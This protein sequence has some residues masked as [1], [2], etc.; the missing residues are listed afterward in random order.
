MPSAPSSRFRSLASHLVSSILLA[1]CATGEA[2][3]SPE[4][5]LLAHYESGVSTDSGALD[6]ANLDHWWTLYDDPQLVTWIDAAFQGAFSLREAKARLVEARA[7]RSVALAQ[8]DPQGNL[9]AQGEYRRTRDLDSEQTATTKSASASLPVAWEV[10]FFGRRS[11]SAGG[12]DAD[13]AAARFQ[14]ESARAATAAEVARTLFQVRGFAAQ[15]RETRQSLRIAQELQQLVQAR[16]DRG[17]APRSEVDR[18]AVEAGQATAQAEDLQAALSASR[19]ALLVAVGRGTDALGA[20]AAIFDVDTAADELGTAP[21]VPAALP[22][23][24]LVRRPDLRLA[25]ARIRKAG[26]A[27][28]LAELDFFPRLTINPGVGLN[29]Q[30][31]GL[32]AGDFSFWSIGAGLALP[33]LDRPRLQAELDAA[34]A[35]GEQAVLAFERSVQTAFSEADEV[36]TRLAADR[37]RVDTLANGARRARDAYDAAQQRY[38]LGFAGLQEVLDGERAWRSAR[39]AL[40]GARLDALQRSVQVFQ[41]LGGGWSPR[42]PASTPHTSTHSSTSNHANNPNAVN[43]VQAHA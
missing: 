24:L 20:G 19:R 6:P 3:R 4:V 21:E 31:G 30:R 1:A 38:E 43:G 25:Q 23:D 40:I 37:R 2:P 18:V 5:Q 12:A 29:A 10:D 36:L 33:L 32:G 8:Y 7:L 13:I 27:V 35:R 15:L 11:A 28:K 16:A 9:S 42:Q 14:V 34:G 22:G 26:S 17:L 41:A 39:L